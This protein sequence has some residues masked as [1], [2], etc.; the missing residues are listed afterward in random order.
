[1]Q[2]VPLSPS[3]FSVLLLPAVAVA[4]ES[5]ALFHAPVVT[6]TVAE[7]QILFDGDGDGDLDILGTTTNA[8]GSTWQTAIYV[9]ENNGGAFTEVWTD[10]V[11]AGT[12]GTTPVATADL[13]GDGLDDFVIAGRGTA[14][15]F[16]SQPGWTFAVDYLVQAVIQDGSRAVAIGD[17]DGDGV[18]DVAVAAEDDGSTIASLD[19]FL[20]TGQ[21]LTEPIPVSWSSPVRLEAL[22]LDGV[23]GIDLLYS[24]RT[25][26]TAH[27]YV[28]TAG[29][30]QQAQSFPSLL[31]YNGGTPWAWTGGDLDGDG[32]T[33]VVCFRPELGANGVPHCQVFRRTG[34]ATFVSEPVAIGG[35]AERLVDVDGDGDLDGVGYGVG[36]SAWE[37]PGPALEIA[38]NDGAGG[39]A[40]AW[41]VPGT[42]SGELAGVADLDADGDLD[43]VA[44]RFIFYGDGP[45][46]REPMPMVGGKEATRVVR[47]WAFGDIDRDGDTDQLPYR[48]NRGDGQFAQ[49]YEP[50]T[51]PVGFS[52]GPPKLCDVDGDGNLDQLMGLYAPGTLP[53]FQQMV[54]AR[55]NGGNHFYYVGV[56]AAPGLLVGNPGLSRADD[57]LSVDLDGDGDQERIYNTQSLSGSNG[58]S[59]VFWNQGGTFV[60]GP[61][62]PV[63][64]GG[65][66]DLVADFD[67]DGLMDLVMRGNTTGIHVRRGTGV[68]GSWFVTEWSAPFMPMEPGATILG[69][70]NDD[71]RMDFVRPNANGELVLFVN[72]STGP[73]NIGFDAFPLV[74][75]EL[76]VVTSFSSA[77][78]RA[79]VAVADF[80]QD[81]MTDIAIGRIPGEPNVGLVLRRTS[82][83]N[84]PTLADYDVVRQVFIDGYGQ[85][86]DADGDVDLI[87]TVMT[88]NRHWGGSAAG[89]RIQLY[90]GVAG[91]DGAV[92]VLGATGPFRVG[93]TEVL[94]L[95]S[96]PGPTVSILGI[97]L[98]EL[99]QP[100]VPLPGLTLHLD[101]ATT[102]IGTLPITEDGLG[103]AAAS[104]SLP[105]QLVNGLQGFRFYVQAFVFDPQATQAFSQSNL[106][107][108]T[109]GG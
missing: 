22:D 89:S 91:E 45:W 109:I 9:L 30:L 107:V 3:L 6:D 85:D 69:D 28:V 61:S 54:W 100:N 59:Q 92:P 10:T 103:H 37:W 64:G 19:V 42:G 21:T 71:G 17:F 7:H 51:A 2:R 34:L 96:V 72:T 4:Q 25:S 73:G 52:F 20:A 12:T 94:T 49:V 93:E 11:S 70:V 97:A 23:G 29:Q 58:A 104:A 38:I 77:P 36:G 39:F 63:V 5:R 83:S 84:P 62:F 55:N 1:M 106:L 24:D 43:I 95:T 60:A 16:L 88:R 47:P 108:K 82:F 41:R 74:G 81:G 99:T 32:D 33:D 15:R 26:D 35:P 13:N 18:P 68:S 53:Q 8:F 86:G 66:V 27:A 65:R 50:L 67:Q 48:I 76:I 14:V 57:G 75:E 56:C 79:S 102:L 78:V 87:A 80:D 90:D 44:S 46:D 40:R 105:I 98:G 101:P 31:N